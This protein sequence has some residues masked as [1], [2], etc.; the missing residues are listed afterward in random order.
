LS[1]VG[2][3]AVV[4]CL[5]PC[6]RCQ[7]PDPPAALHCTDTVADTWSCNEKSGHVTYLD[8]YCAK[9]VAD[10]TAQ[11]SPNQGTPTAFSQG[12]CAPVTQFVTPTFTGGYTLPAGQGVCLY[13][14]PPQSTIPHFNDY[15]W[16]DEVLHAQQNCGGMQPSYAPL[17]DGTPCG[18]YRT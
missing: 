15:G 13:T 6:T 11:A 2:G 12:D 10:G 7:R 9:N 1:M 18:G 5:D 14:E 16:F 8:L 4:G 3:G 17:P